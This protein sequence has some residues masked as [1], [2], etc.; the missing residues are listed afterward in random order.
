[1][2]NF[3]KFAK[4][5]KKHFETDGR[6]LEAALKEA[7]ANA[8]EAKQI[9]KYINNRVKS[10]TGKQKD[11]IIKKVLGDNVKKEYKQAFERLI[12]DSHGGGLNEIK[13]KNTI[14]ETLGVT[15]LKPEQRKLITDLANQLQKAPMGSNERKFLSAR[16]SV[17][18]QDVSPIKKSDM[19]KTLMFTGDLLN[20]TTLMKN[21]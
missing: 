10:A 11:E 6:N 9:E 13:V 20:T 18:I 3:C 7:G 4:A 17:A 2:A 5:I 12:D 14:G 16:L 19:A 1:M 21:T 8:D 15:S